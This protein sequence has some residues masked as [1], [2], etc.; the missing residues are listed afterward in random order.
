M[1]TDR[2]PGSGG[3]GGAEP[4]AHAVRGLVFQFAVGVAYWLL[5]AA[6]PERPLGYREGTAY[7]RSAP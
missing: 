6:V 1:L 2:A 5:L 3:W 4:R 7:P